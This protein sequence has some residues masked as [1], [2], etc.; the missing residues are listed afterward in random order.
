VGVPVLKLRGH[1][2]AMATLGLGEIMYVVLNAAVDLTSGPSGFGE[3][4]RI[5]LGDFTVSSQISRYYLVWS[6]VLAVLAFSLNIIHSR[7][8]RA[9][10]SIHGSEVAANAMGVDTS[11]YKVQVF[12]LSAAYASIAGSLYA[13]FITFVSPSS[14]SLKF[15]ILLV[16]M[17][18]VG[19]MANV[20]GAVLGTA[21][22]GILPEVLR[23]F[24]DF[25]ILI[26]GFILLIMV[27]FAPEGLFGLMKRV[28]GRWS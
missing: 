21:V 7:V 17:V 8:G 18:V 1:Y 6:I 14:F 2:L 25:D 20:W 22:L 15:S 24:K 23:S 3:I 11:K 16:T 9:L 12:V 19:G 28:I 26:Y 4:P 13:H 10:R 27:M 5:R